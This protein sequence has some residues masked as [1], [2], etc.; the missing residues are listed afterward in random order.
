MTEETDIIQ[1]VLQGDTELFAVLVER[2]QKPVVRMV[3]N[4]TCDGPATEDIAQDVFLAAFAKLATFDPARSRFSTWLF[5][6]TRNKCINR[7]KKKRPVCMRQLPERGRQHAPDQHAVRNELLARLDRALEALP[8]RQRR[9]FVLAEFEA[10]PY[11]EIAQIEGARIGTV[12][13]R[14]N[15]ARGKLADVLKRYGVDEP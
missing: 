8:A 5:T 2:Y 3:R 6:I 7:M 9:A 15:R 4:L 11:E 14:I 1:R 10:L 12:K 13:S